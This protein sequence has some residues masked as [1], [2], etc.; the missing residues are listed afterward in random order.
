MTITKPPIDQRI[1]DAAAKAGTAAAKEPMAT[2]IL[3]VDYHRKPQ[4]VQDAWF[5]AFMK[6]FTA[7]RKDKP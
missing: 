2:A 1:L 7:N 5:N 3:P 4:E 6:Q